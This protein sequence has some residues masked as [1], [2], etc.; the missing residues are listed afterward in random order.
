MCV[1][2]YLHVQ[3]LN[4]LYASRYHFV[5]QERTKLTRN[6]LSVTSK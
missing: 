3:L 2:N 4:K 6:N 1:D 5:D